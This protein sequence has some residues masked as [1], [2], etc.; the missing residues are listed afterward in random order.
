MTKFTNISASNFAI[1][2]LLRHEKNCKV[3]K[4][5]NISFNKIFVQNS[6]SITYIVNNNNFLNDFKSNAIEI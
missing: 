4:S 6:N 5:L 3:R 1:N 2:F